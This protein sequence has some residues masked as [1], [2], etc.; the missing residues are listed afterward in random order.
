MQPLRQNPISN[1]CE[2]A[3]QLFPQKISKNET[4]VH[5]R[6]G[7]GQTGNLGTRGFGSYC[8]IDPNRITFAKFIFGNML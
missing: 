5:S 6:L 3:P 4:W 7:L 8:Q 1:H 2:S